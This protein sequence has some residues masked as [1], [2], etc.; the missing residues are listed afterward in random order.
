MYPHETTSLIHL[1]M[2]LWAA[3]YVESVLFRVYRSNTS[4]K[5]TCSDPT[6]PAETVIARFVTLFVTPKVM[7]AVNGGAV[8]LHLTASHVLLVFF[9]IFS[10]HKTR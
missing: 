10:R 8:L 4:G 6:M 2:R 9:V 5:V 7:H 1:D 3:P